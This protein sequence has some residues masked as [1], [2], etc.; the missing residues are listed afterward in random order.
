MVDLA[1]AKYGIESLDPTIKNI[2]IAWG[3]FCCFALETHP[4]KHLPAC[5]EVRKV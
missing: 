3:Y 1:V 2:P 4:L 5:E